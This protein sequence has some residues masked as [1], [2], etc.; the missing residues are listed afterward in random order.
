M[1]YD[2]SC[3]KISACEFSSSDAAAVSS[4]TAE[5]LCVTIEICE[6]PSL[7]CAIASACS[8]EAMEMLLISDDTSA[9]FLTIISNDCDVAS[10]MLDPLS[11]RLFDVS[12]SP[13]VSVADS[14]LR[15]A[16]LRTSSA[17]T[18]KPLPC[19]LLRLLLRR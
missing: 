4:E 5:L 3:R 8:F 14:W 11:T 15:P 12:I 10:A 7:I 1:K 19:S 17:T 16:R 2:T 18:L 13:V 9:A 6:S